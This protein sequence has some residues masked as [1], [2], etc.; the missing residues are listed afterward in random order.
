MT[1]QC[2][3]CGEPIFIG[4]PV[5]LYLPRYEDME[6]PGHAVPYG[7]GA[8]VGC[9]RW[10]CAESGTD[11]V[12]FWYPPGIVYRVLSPIEQ[13]LQSDEMVIIGDLG[14][15]RQAIPIEMSAEE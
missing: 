13:C 3:W 8:F 2:A 11:R 1:I 12:G 6:V 14:D 7:K 15:I 10:E 5:T 4:D 9:L